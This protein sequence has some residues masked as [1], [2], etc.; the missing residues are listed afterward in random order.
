MRHKAI[1]L[2]QQRVASSAWPD[3]AYGL[4]ALRE[5]DPQMAKGRLE[6]IQDLQRRSE[7][8]ESTHDPQVV[9]D[10]LQA[11]TAFLNEEA[12]EAVRDEQQDASPAEEAPMEDESEGRKTAAEAD[13]FLKYAPTPTEEK[14][15]K[16]A[17]AALNSRRSAGE[18]DGF[19]KYAPTPAPAGPVATD[20]EDE[21]ESEAG[22][23]QIT[24]EACGHTMNMGEAEDDGDDA[25]MESENEN[26]SEGGAKRKESTRG[27]APKKEATM[28]AKEPTEAAG[29]RK[30]AEAERAELIGL[31]K[32]CNEA[33]R[34]VRATKLIETQQATGL[35]TED[36]LLEFK[37]SQWPVLITKWTGPTRHYGTGERAVP[38][39]PG[40]TA[41]KS[42]ADIFEERLAQ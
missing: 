7:A 15:E 32:R 33:D 22:G 41:P 40:R 29:P 26:E 42:A 5:S 9:Q 12:E 19:A 30:L 34:R 20:P 3:V 1:E 10:L 37:E 28:E 11:L 16:D 14:P 38:A 24:C 8:V 18:A 31:R 13:G 21:D 6:Q 2:L 4:Q 36:E 23:K 27:R 17:D 39:L 25:G 35:V